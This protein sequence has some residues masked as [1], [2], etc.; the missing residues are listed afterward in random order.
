MMSRLPRNNGV[1][2]VY[3]EKTR[4][5]EPLS[6]PNSSRFSSPEQNF[7]DS[8]RKSSSTKLRVWRPYP[9]QPK[10]ISQQHESKHDFDLVDCKESPRTNY[11]QKSQKKWELTKRVYHG[12]K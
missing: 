12:Q 5:G 8:A 2:S 4:Y 3:K 7:T 10:I 11:N 9:I 6:T 1:T